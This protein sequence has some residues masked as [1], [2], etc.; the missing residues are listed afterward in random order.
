MCLIVLA[1]KV[2]PRFPLILA[3]NRDE[4]LDRP[5]KPAH[6]WADA[7]DILAGRDKRAG[8]TWLGITKSGRFAAVTNYRNMRMS[9]PPGPSRGLL[10]R[11][12]LEEGIDPR[13]TGAY[14]GFSLIHGA[15]DHLRY[16]NN[17]NGVDEPISQGIHGLSNHF[18]NTPWPKVVKAKQAMKRLLELPV[19]EMKD[20]LFHLLADD[21][22]AP[23]KALPDTG[24]P[25][26]MERAAS[27]IFI[28]TPGYG[29]RCSTVVLVEKEGTVRFK[30][31]IFPEKGTIEEQFR[32]E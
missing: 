14:A 6:F 31:R 26:E 28:H 17:I 18:L 27:S 16:H 20:G 1:Y 23:D 11:Q 30:E 29:T 12:A 4:F 7:P 24:L 10:V 2:H 3:A 32:I 15:L 21:G 5:A 22:I 9:F 13:N 25:L 19:A 8:G